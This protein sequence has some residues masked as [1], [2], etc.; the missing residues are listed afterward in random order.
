MTTEIEK[1]SL[2]LE[3]LISKTPLTK[4]D[5][6]ILEKFKKEKPAEYERLKKEADDL[7]EYE[8]WI[9]LYGGKLGITYETYCNADRD[10]IVY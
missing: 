8:T 7:V 10:R 5:L 2:L 3:N 9:E 1:S 4:V 6:E